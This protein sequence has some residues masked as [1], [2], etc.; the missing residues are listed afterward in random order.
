[1]L[2]RFLYLGCLAVCVLASVYGQSTTSN[3][4]E[5]LP[6]G[7]DANGSPKGEGVKITQTVTVRNGVTFQYVY[8]YRPDPSQKG[9]FITTTKSD[10]GLDV[11]TTENDTT[12]NKEI[13]NLCPNG[14]PGHPGPFA[15]QTAL[16]RG[17]GD[18]TT[19]AI[20]P[21]TSGPANQ[22]LVSFNGVGTI[23]AALIT[24]SGIAVTLFNSDGTMLSTATYPVAGIGAG[25]LAADFDG[26]GIQ[27]LAA[28]QNGT[29]GPGNV[30][31][32]LGKSDGTF[33]PP[34][35]FTAGSFPFYLT[36]GDFDGD[37]VPDL[38]VTNLSANLGTAGAVTVLLG[39]GDGTFAPA[40]GYPVG[41]FPGTIVAADFDGDGNVDLAALDTQTGI[42]N[43]TNKVWVLL[44]RGDGTFKPALLTATGTGSGYLSF[45][46]VNNDG[47]LDLIIADQFASAMAIMLGKGDG[48]FQPSKEYVSAAQ[49][50]VTAPIPLTDG[51]TSILSGRRHRQRP[52]AVFY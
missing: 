52:D 51:T 18:R 44:G 14:V 23:D 4:C 48:T 50:T 34:K 10:N 32:L 20:P 7:Q 19:A 2:R 47:N 16:V 45:A 22:G 11:T 35:A 28:T 42:A 39:K 43:Y 12:A 17:S 29:S 38:A 30:V 1:M 41:E 46:D 37:G 3:R 33:G 9:K 36:T 27:D 21:L 6:G 26:D 25:I 49:T 5:L 31:V 13:M 15:R 24:S 8:T 40:V